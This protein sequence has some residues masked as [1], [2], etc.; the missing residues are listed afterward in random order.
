MLQLATMTQAS[1]AEVV[2]K[3]PKNTVESTCDLLRR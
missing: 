3:V 1:E 2:P